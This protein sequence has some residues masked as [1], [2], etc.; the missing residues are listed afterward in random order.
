MN[1]LGTIL[2]SSLI[3]RRRRGAFGL[4]RRGYRG[5]HAP[6]GMSPLAGIALTSLAAYGARKYMASRNA[7]S[8]QAE[9]P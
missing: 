1:I 2:A 4:P 8:T 7:A 9:V 6:R 3:N 5:R